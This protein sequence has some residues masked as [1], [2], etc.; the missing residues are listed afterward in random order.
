MCI[1]DKHTHTHKIYSA[2]RPYC[3]YVDR[4]ES[5]LNVCAFIVR[6]RVLGTPAK[7]YVHKCAPVIHMYY[8]I[9]YL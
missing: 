7:L 2:D 3:I 9:V 4:N 1:H 8:N 6:D 5:V